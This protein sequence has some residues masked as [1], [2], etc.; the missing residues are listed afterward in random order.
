MEQRIIS[1]SA[2]ETKSLAR[3]LLSKL[4]G[5]NVIALYG[6]L[7][8]GKT[9]FVQGLAK[10]LGIEKRIISPTFIVVRSYRLEK[11]FFDNFNYLY[12]IDLYRITTKKEIDELGLLEVV[13]NPENLVVIEWAEKM[14]DL[15]PKKRIDVEFEYINED[16][17]KIVIVYP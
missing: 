15:L 9:T 8:S 12:H 6:E 11:F 17:R 7:G 1:S 16:K 10:N 2:Q 13:K 14:K 4:A 5:R 3:K